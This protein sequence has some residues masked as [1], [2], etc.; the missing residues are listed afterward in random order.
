MA[1]PAN[2]VSGNGRPTLRTSDEA[3]AG[4]K[5]VARAFGGTVTL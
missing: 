4:S 5:T 2:Q 1:V 3:V